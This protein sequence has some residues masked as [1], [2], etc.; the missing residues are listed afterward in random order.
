MSGKLRLLASLLFLAV[1]L[2]LT[3]SIVAFLLREVVAMHLPTTDVTAQLTR[4]Q[5]DATIRQRWDTLQRSYECCGGHEQ[6]YRDWL[7]Q[8]PRRGGVPDSCCKVETEGCGNVPFLSPNAIPP[9]PA[10]IHVEGCMVVIKDSLHGSVLPGL[11][12]CALIGLVAGLIE[13]LLML[14]SCCFA[15]HVKKVKDFRRT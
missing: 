14:M 5:S 13:L 6:G 12:A 1:L 9:I 4:Y 7:A 10:V 2:S 3:A 11:L 8:G 15:D